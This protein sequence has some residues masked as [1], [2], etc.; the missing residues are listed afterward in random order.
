MSGAKADS[1]F[2]IYCFTGASVM[3]CTS[4]K[5]E[6][7]FSFIF[8]HASGE[9]FFQSIFTSQNRYNFTCGGRKLNVA[10]RKRAAEW[11][12]LSFFFLRLRGIGFFLVVQTA[13]RLE[14]LVAQLRVKVDSEA[15]AVALAAL[16]AV[17][18][19]LEI[20]FEKR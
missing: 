13:L 2:I 5:T 4:A 1:H 11:G 19:Y 20:L 6:L 15:V 10:L 14:V 18:C 7:S 12:T 16:A 3:H 8:S 9:D 17:K